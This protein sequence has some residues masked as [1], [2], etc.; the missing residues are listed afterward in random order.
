MEPETVGAR[1]YS[2]P[3]ATRDTP[4]ARDMNA[5]LITYGEPL[6]FCRA[7]LDGVFGAPPLEVVPERQRY[8]KLVRALMMFVASSVVGIDPR[9]VV[10]P[11]AAMELMHTASLVHDDLVDGS[12][13]R[14]GLPALHAQIGLPR[15]LVL[16][17]LM[18][19]TA[20]GLIAEGATGFPPDRAVAA[21][22]A[23]ARAATR[24]ARGELAD[25]AAG[26]AP[27]SPAV[28]VD[29]AGALFAFAV[30]APALLSGADPA[31]R[32]ALERFGLHVGVAYQARDDWLD[33]DADGHSPSLTPLA[34]STHLRAALEELC[35]LPHSPAL[36]ELEVIA[37]FATTRLA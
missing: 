8:G 2:R 20:V 18:L 16:G 21:V 7:E 34:T 11:A 31:Q 23:L 22:A 9:S 28:A 3:P 37:R 29:K 25:I 33:R 6:G 13:T 5:L 19:M 14:R 10:R 30:S 27:G 36:F 12:S 4:A 24:C 17:D 15:A 1:T 32:V 26:P 35:A